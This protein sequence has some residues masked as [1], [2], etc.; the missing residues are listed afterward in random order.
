MMDSSENPKR[1]AN[2]FLVP[3]IASS[4]YDWDA[5]LPLCPRGAVHSSTGF[6]PHLLWTG[7]EL[8]LPADLCYPLPT[9]DPSTPQDFTTPLR[10]VIRSAHNAA[11]IALG[12]ASLH[13]NQQFDRHTSGAPYQIGDLV[14]HHDPDPLAEPLLNSTKHGEDLA[15][16]DSTLRPFNQPKTTIMETVQFTEG[17]ALTEL[18]RLKESTSPGPNEILAKILKEFP[19][20][21]E[22]K[23]PGVESHFTPYHSGPRDSSGRH[24]VTIAISQQADLALL[25]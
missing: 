9:A 13:Q 22:I 23:I 25:A 24:G 11:R 7:C 12:V 20:S 14:M 15:K 18:M 19:G 4:S 8:R 10:E 6:T 16:Q 1:Q 17:M 3:V 5:H 2:K 21:R